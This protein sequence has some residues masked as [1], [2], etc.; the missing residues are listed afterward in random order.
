G[1]VD[2]GK[3]KPATVVFLADMDQLSALMVLANYE[4]ECNETA[5]IPF[6]AGCQQIGIYP[7][8][9]ALREHPRAVVGLTDISARVQIKRQLKDDVM[10]LAVPFAMFREM[11]ANVPGSFLERNTWKEI[12]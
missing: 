6:A 5:I 1:Q 2:D 4:R 3:E 10:S 12:V 9:E 7:F 8:D 11:E